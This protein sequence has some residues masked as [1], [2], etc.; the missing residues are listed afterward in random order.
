MN[1]LNP[2]RLVKGKVV[3]M[4][5]CNADGIDLSFRVVQTKSLLVV[6]RYVYD[7]VAND[8][9]GDWSWANLKTLPVEQFVEATNYAVC[10]FTQA[11]EFEGSK[12]PFTFRYQDFKT[13]LLDGEP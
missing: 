9:G 1:D 11:V 12:Q 10:A 3:L 6:Q 7:P 8:F 5:D 13:I 4:M 2:K